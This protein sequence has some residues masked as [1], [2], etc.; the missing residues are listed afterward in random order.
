[1]GEQRFRGRTNEDR[2]GRWY[3]VFTQSEKEQYAQKN[4]LTQDFA[5][6]CPMQRRTIRHARRIRDVCRPLFPRYLFVHLDVSRDLWLQIN[7]TFG[8]V[9]LV[10]SGDRPI[11]VPA[12]VVECLLE[13]SDRKEIVSR[14]A[15]ESFRPG[16]RVLVLSG[17]FAGQVSQ[18]YRLDDRGRVCFLL[19]IMGGAVPVW[20]T[21]GDLAKAS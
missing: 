6:F 20:T 13:V 1:M 11:P 9:G 10:M 4:L 17:P 19:S 8:V 21:P 12:G 14:E 5:S 16:D 18:V 2:D 7:R 3:C 15:L